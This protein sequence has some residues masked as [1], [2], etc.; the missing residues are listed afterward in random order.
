MEE[1]IRKGDYDDFLPELDVGDILIC[2]SVCQ[3]Q[4]KEFSI[5]YFEEFVHLFMHGF[6]HVWGYDHELN[7]KEE[8]LMFD[9]EKQLV[10]KI[11]EIKKES[12]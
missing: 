11:S 12:L 8:K 3:A 4:A 2:K 6:L 9:L 7:E 10:E 1:N 5:S